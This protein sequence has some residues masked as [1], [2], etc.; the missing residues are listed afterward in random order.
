MDK[1]TVRIV[2]LTLGV[3]IIAGVYVWGRYKR[4]VLDFLRRRG[5]YDESGYGPSTRQSAEPAEPSAASGPEED[6]DM[7][8]SLNY[9]GTGSRESGFSGGHDAGGADNSVFAEP[10]ASAPQPAKPKPVKAGALGA[11]FLIQISVVA[12][13]DRFFRGEDLRDA[14]LEMD[15]VHGSMGI[16]HRY[17]RAYRESLFGVASLVEPGTFPM[18]MDSFECPGV[19]LFFQPAQ[20]SNPLAV[21]DDLVATC[22]ELAS[23]LG[24]I[25]WDET[26]QPLTPDKIAHMRAL[27]EDACE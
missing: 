1:D 16:F 2:L 21:F 22:H 14:L 10:A 26:R 17:D 24:G 3:L 9:T 7:F 4:K 11:P 12:G 8:D 23:R 6:E 25:E 27:L 5:E 18:F 13:R 19:V 15:L 20:V